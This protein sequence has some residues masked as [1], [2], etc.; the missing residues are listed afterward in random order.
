[1]KM[2][3]ILLTA[4]IFAGALLET[5]AQAAVTAP[6]LET[7]MSATHADQIIYYAQ[8]IA[9]MIESGTNTYN[10]FQNLLRA[11]QMALN[12]LKGI[13]SVK[14]FGDFMTW[15]NRQ[16]YLEQQTENRFNNMGVK[17]GGRTYKVADV[18][19][20]PNA[21]KTEF[22]DYWGTEFSE[23]Q[24]KEMWIN[25]GLSPSN[26]AYVQTW[27]AREDEL[28]KSIMTKREIVNEENMA[29]AER[30]NEMLKT[31]EEDAKLPE[32]QRMGEKSML[33]MNL[34]AQLEGNRL[35][36]SSIYDQAEAEERQ[37]MKEQ[38]EKPL[39]NPPDVSD[40]WG[41]DTMFRPF[42]N[43]LKF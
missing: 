1:M 26:Y 10:Q 11:E 34:M 17:I 24:K 21:M 35:L 33:Q 8:S 25:L 20:I 36:R 38:A 30:E 31:L 13:A 15:Y 32:D 29:A 22:V 9:Q 27:K 19:D 41:N 7:I 43:E 3:R 37:L 2:K 5:N 6:I 39:P 28:A 12:N 4:A 18:S 42:S 16:L 14:S 23:Q 40:M